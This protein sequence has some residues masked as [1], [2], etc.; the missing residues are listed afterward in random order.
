VADYTA[1]IATAH[2]LLEKFGEESTLVRTVNGTP[3]DPTKPWIPGT[4][5]VTTYLVHAVWLNESILRRES[6]VKQGE[7]FALLAALDLATV[8][9]DPSTD[10]LVRA[11]GRRYAI[12]ENGPLDPSGQ[13]I[14]YEV[15]VRS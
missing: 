6:L 15:K 7:V 2:R 14:I 12:V 1:I 3:S 10:H 4:A 5:V 9:P 8:V 13:A 11:D